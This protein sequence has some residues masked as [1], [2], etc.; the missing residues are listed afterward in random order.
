[1]KVFASRFFKRGIMILKWI[2]I[3]IISI[4][5][6]FVLV[7]FIARGL[8]KNKTKISTINGIQENSY[9]EIGGIEQFIQIRG[10]DTNNPIILFLHGGPG[11]PH[12]Y[13]SHYYQKDLEAGYTIVNWDQRGSG[14][15]YYANSDF[16]G[17]IGLSMENLLDDLDEIVDYLTERF[18]QEELVIMGHSWGSILGSLYTKEYPEKVSAYIGVGQTVNMLK[19]ETMSVGAA[20]ELAMKDLNEEYIENLSK[21]FNEFSNTKSYDELNFKNFMNMRNLASEYLSQETSSSELKAIW[22]GASSPHMSIRDIKWFLKPMLNFEEFL[23]IEKPL[24]EYSFFD[25]NLS[26]HGIEYEVPVYF[27]SG[28][29]DWITPYKLVEEYYESI[30][31]PKKEMILIENAGHM[32]F[33]DNPKG[34]SDAVIR[35]LD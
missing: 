12:A 35:V 33:M 7:I 11:S 5:L 27:I 28:D 24:F 17:E 16:D 32:T 8:N 3:A 13:V 4:I 1:M 18:E 19:A 6:L 15:T 30:E 23:E 34:F 29:W 31:S 10:E 14:R 25:F 26:E 21:T 9:I 2:G 20:K 22:L